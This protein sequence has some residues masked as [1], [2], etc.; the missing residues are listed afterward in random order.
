MLLASEPSAVV[1]ASIQSFDQTETAI[2]N[3]KNKDSWLQ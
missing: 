2:T 1:V 3:H